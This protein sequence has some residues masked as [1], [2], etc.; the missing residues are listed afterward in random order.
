MNFKCLVPL[1]SNTLLTRTEDLIIG[2]H[3]LANK[4]FSSIYILGKENGRIMKANECAINYIYEVLNKILFNNPCEENLKIVNR[5]ENNGDKILLLEPEEIVNGTTNIFGEMYDI[6]NDSESY[7]T[8]SLNDVVEFLGLEDCTPEAVINSLQQ[9]ISSQMPTTTTTTT[10]LSTTTVLSQDCANED[11][12][13]LRQEIDILG[14][15]VPAWSILATAVTAAGLVSAGIGYFIGK[16]TQKQDFASKNINSEAISL[17]V[18]KSMRNASLDEKQ[19]SVDEVIPLV[20]NHVIYTVPS[21]DRVTLDVSLSSEYSIPSDRVTPD[22][23]LSSE[24]SVPSNN[25]EL[26]AITKLAGNEHVVNLI[27]NDE[28]NGLYTA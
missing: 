15:K 28:H 16:Y 12:N 6:A 25:V 18:Q 23:S 9:W 11:N 21:S 17:H 26:Y 3:G 27:G 13:W 20:N 2:M 22:V 24:Y 8:L 7:G 14:A 4:T 5:V 1:F 19:D 10:E